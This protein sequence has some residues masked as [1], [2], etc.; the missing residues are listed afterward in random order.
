M[1][2]KINMI[3]DNYEEL[4]TELILL[5]YR[6]NESLSIPLE[7][8]I[9]IDDY[10]KKTNQLNLYLYEL[11]L[12]ITKNVNI[13]FSYSNTIWNLKGKIKNKLN[14]LE[15]L[16]LDYK[17]QKVKIRDLRVCSDDWLNGI[18]RNPLW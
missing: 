7:N 10:I 13:K 12:I 14:L 16:L 11:N 5:E 9:T 1:I 2:I 17:L 6:I 8:L 3:Q 15:H 18:A 4:T